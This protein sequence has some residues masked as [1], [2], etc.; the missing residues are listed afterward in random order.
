MI[1]TTAATQNCPDMIALMLS[2][3]GALG[4]FHL[5]V[6]RILFQNAHLPQIISGA[7]A[8]A[9]VAAM[10]CTR[11]P[12][13]LGALLSAEADDMAW[14][15]PQRQEFYAAMVAVDAMQAFVDQVIPDL[16]FAES[17]AISG[18]HLA[19]SVAAPRRKDDGLILCHLTSPDVLVRD[20]VLASCAVPLIFS[21]KAIRTRINGKI[22]AFQ[23][24]HRWIDGSIFADL[25]KAQL[26]QIFGATQ[27]IASMV[28]PAAMPFIADAADLSGWAMAAPDSGLPSSMTDM[29]A[30]MNRAMAQGLSAMMDS[31]TSLV[32]PM[33]QP[34]LSAIPMTGNMD[35]LSDYWSRIA[36][37]T[38]DADV[39][40]L[41]RSGYL[42]AASMMQLMTDDQ[43]KFVIAEGELST[44]KKLEAI[45]SL[46][47]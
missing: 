10:L 45:I 1:M 17:F 2:G 25:P 12:D 19:I 46:A 42:D 13:A 5:G 37:Q 44:R 47:A 41:P 34:L 31:G 26:A 29:M 43:R 30:T 23:G 28:N 27:F 24:Q 22:A 6:A 8:G 3:G 14:L 33:L 11:A 32:A 7:S 35:Y 20:A 36:T 9:L 40:I 39:M 18:R 15:D 38:Y 21:P 4:N 16:T